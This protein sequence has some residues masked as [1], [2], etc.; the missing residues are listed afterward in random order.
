VTIEPGANITAS[1]PAPVTAD[2]LPATLPTGADAKPLEFDKKSV[3]LKV[4]QS[5]VIQVTNPG[6]AETALSIAS[7][8]PA[9]IEAN[10]DTAKVEAGGKAKLTLRAAKGARSGV[11][12]VRGGD[13]TVPIQV[14]IVK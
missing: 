11:V 10:F 13:A 5:A 14:T 6:T 3:R 2:P 4:G 9:G 8:A 1:A 7:P 12:N